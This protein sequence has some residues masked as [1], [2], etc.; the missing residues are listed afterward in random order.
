M[1]MRAIRRVLA[2]AAMTIAVLPQAASGALAGSTVLVSRPDGF[3]PVPPAFDNDSGTPGALSA[4]GRYAA[5]ISFADGF[6]DGA[7]PS[8]SNVLLR[9]RQTSTTTLVSRS[10]GP[11][12][13]G[14]N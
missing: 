3:G 2:A 14:A 12:G 8:V 6:A 11:N 7:D 1:T 4:D 10:D 9:D 5:Y 13:A